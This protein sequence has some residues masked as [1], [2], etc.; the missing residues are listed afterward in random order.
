[1]S[2]LHHKES[3]SQR[4]HKIGLLTSVFLV[5]S[6]MIGNG[7]YT[8]LGIQLMS[9]PSGFG[10]LVLWT[11][12]G[13]VAL[14]GALS[15]AEIASYLPHSGGDYYYLAHIYHPAIGTMAGIITLLAGFVAPIALASMAFGKYFQDF[16]PGVPPMLSSML[17]VTI[18][19]IAHLLHWNVSV[20]FQNTLTILKFVLIAGIIVFG[21]YYTSLSP[22][23]L[24]PSKRAF[25]ELLE[26]TSGVVLLFCFYAYSGWNSSVYIADDII[27]SRKTVGW[28]LVIGTLLVIL[29]YLLLNTIFLL[30][31]PIS[32]L[33]GTLNVGTIVAIH[34]VGPVGGRIMAGLI[35]IGLVSGI[36]GMIWIGPRMTQAMGRDLVALRWL[37]PVSRNHVPIRSTLLQYLLVLVVLA[38]GSFK[39]V[40]VTTQVP[41]IFCSLLGVIGLIVLRQR[42]LKTETVT[43]LSPRR[44]FRCPLY[45]LPSLC[46]ALLSLLALIYTIITNPLEAGVGGLIILVALGC[47]P[48]LKKKN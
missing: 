25:Q 48:I 5:A 30:A 18:I 3:S 33:Q 26:P 2:L 42:Y 39:A 23:I 32:A 19:T 6:V 24:L 35:A 29:L 16:F 38:T 12:A 44:G 17:L 28:S 20:L 43:S 31:A 11:L 15:Y 36:S 37:S 8:S 34:L 4:P 14:C 40:L 9:I 27:S 13:I 46:F 22:K 47:Y 7:I 41:I 45:P 10:I 1:M 21:F